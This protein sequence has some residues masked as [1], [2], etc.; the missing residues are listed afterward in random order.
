MKILM[1]KSS[2]PINIFAKQSKPYSQVSQLQGI[3][4]YLHKNGK[5]GNVDI[6]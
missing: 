2:L 1:K 3:K 5:I 6:R 4:K